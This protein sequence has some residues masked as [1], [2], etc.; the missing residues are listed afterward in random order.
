MLRETRNPMRLRTIPRI[1]C[2]LAVALMVSNADADIIEL[3]SGERIEGKVV[4]V[5]DDLVYVET[6]DGVVLLPRRTVRSMGSTPAVAP[7]A[8]PAGEVVTV[9]KR[10]QAAAASP[11]SHKEYA[12]QVAQSRPV[13]AKYLQESSAAPPGGADAVRDAFALY[14]FAAA[15]WE[16]RLT[17]SAPASAAI[18]RSATIDRCPALQKV[19]ANYPPATDQETAWRR[20]VAIEFEIPSIL[21]CA[22][23]KV[24]EAERALKR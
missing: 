15:A 3:V 18:G 2:A 14:E 17:N 22:S 4:L 9:L 6:G 19:V 10:L 16:S 7:S 20:G 13:V 5:T 21:T 23:E 1:V 8:A 11:T 24:A 12:A